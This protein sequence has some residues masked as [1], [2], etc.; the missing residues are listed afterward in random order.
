VQYRTAG[1]AARWSTYRALAGG[2]SPAELRVLA[3]VH[4]LT[5]TF[6]RLE[7]WITLGQVAVV[8]GLWEGRPRECPRTVT[9]NVARRLKALREMDSVVYEPSIAEGPGNRSRIGIPLPYRGLNE[10]PIYGVE[11]TP[12]RGLGQPREGG[13][14]NPPPEKAA[15]KVTRNGVT[16]AAA[17]GLEANGTPPTRAARVAEL[18]ETIG[19]VYD[20]DDAEARS[21]ASELVELLDA[22]G[23]GELFERPDVADLGPRGLVELAR[24]MA[25]Q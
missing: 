15:G 19:Y 5:A 25:V 22:D 20:V 8:A 11:R 10:P 23:I 13:S 14:H 21:C 7:D 3:A 24:L 9:K 2:A 17:S 6:S 1:R 16:S 18:E 12:E 4:Y